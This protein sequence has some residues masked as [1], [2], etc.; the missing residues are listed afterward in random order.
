[1]NNKNPRPGG[2]GARVSFAFVTRLNKQS[3]ER[4]GNRG[5]TRLDRL[6]NVLITIRRFLF[7]ERGLR[8]RNYPSHKENRLSAG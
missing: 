8:P 5:E 3:V 7:H 4:S 6:F 2:I 1:M